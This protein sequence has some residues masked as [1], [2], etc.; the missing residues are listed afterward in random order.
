MA[1]TVIEIRAVGIVSESHPD[2]QPLYDWLASHEVDVAFIV[3]PSEIK[4]TQKGITTTEYLHRDGT[5][6][7][8]PK[9]P[10][11]ALTAQVLY[12]CDAYPVPTF[13]YLEVT[14][15]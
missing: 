11:K 10:A 2:H 15:G 5:L 6:Q 7:L 9:D 3:I 1:A 4:V 13:K 14:Y 8:D 12:E